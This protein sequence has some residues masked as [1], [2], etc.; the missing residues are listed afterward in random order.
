M[1]FCSRIFYRDVRTTIFTYGLIRNCRLQLSKAFRFLQ[2][3]SDGLYQVSSYCHFITIAKIPKRNEVPTM[4]YFVTLIILLFVHHEEQ[5]LKLPPDV[6]TL[7]QFWPFHKIISGLN[8]QL[9]RW[10]A[11][12]GLTS[13]RCAE[14]WRFCDGINEIQKP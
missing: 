3:S 13:Q 8:G 11:L 9:I 6:F 12:S 2:I 1:V 5:L 7:R 14:P 10:A 4:N